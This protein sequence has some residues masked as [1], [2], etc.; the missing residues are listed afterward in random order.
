MS[1]PSSRRSMATG[2]RVESLESRRLFAAGLPRPDHVVIVV[3]ENRAASQILGSADAPYINSLAAQG[4]SLPAYHGAPPPSQ[5][6]SLALFSGSTQ[7]VTDNPP[8]PP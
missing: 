5:P 8:P 4:A 6:N 3:E 1:S 7:G 2:I